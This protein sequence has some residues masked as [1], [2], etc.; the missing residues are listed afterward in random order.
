MWHRRDDESY[1]YEVVRTVAQKYMADVL[2]ILRRPMF[3]NISH[4]RQ[5]CPSALNSRR[6][7]MTFAIYMTAKCILAYAFLISRRL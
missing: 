7:Y 2:Q 6:A 1:T 4:V 3:A 5:R